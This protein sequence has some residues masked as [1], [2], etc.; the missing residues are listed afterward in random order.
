MTKLL[1]V[2]LLA[3]A[4]AASANTLV[5]TDPMTSPVGLSSERQPPAP[6][7]VDGRIGILLGGSDVGDADG[8]SLG[9]SAGLG[10]RVGDVS[11][12]ALFDYYKVGD[13]HDELLQRKGRATRLGG[14]V[15]YSF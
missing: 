2:A 1:S 9:A 4:S 11:V 12:R 8:S 15:R 10:Y 7:E 5:A 6:R 3:A 13:S 14:A